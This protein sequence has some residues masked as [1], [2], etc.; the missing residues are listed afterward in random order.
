M[1]FQAQI[2]SQPAP[3]VAGDFASANP[4]S[5]VLTGAGGLVA[6]AL[7]VTVGRFAWITPDGLT[8]DSH[9]DVGRLPDGFVH[10]DMQA[11]I[12]TYLTESGMTIPAGFAVTLHNEGDFW[13]LNTGPAALGIND[14]IFANYK[15]GSIAQAAGANASA[16]GSMGATFTATGTGTS[17]V[18]TA[19]TGVITPGET[20]SG[21]G[22]PVGTT[23]VGQVSGTTGGAG[24][25]TTSVATTAAAA[26][27]TSFGV[28]LTVTAVASGSL[29]VGEP[30]TGT[31]IPAL[32]TIA[33]QVSGATG[34]VGTYRLTL[35][36][37][38]YA[39]S[40][41]VTS[42]TSVAV[43]GFKAKSIAAVGE[44]VKM[45]TWG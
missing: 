38:A 25:Y 5:S 6:G 8:A 37:T 42:V 16:T 32:A 9:G 12:T 27:V 33:S 1:G 24:T 22:V 17:L 4:R 3:A 40:T 30:V 43:T 28:F 26:T 10:R 35:P 20:I 18:V 44:L 41:T 34:G 29:D 13:A 15:D 21:T 23:I 14:A 2:N 11:L 31:G 19:V 36:A 45:S 39:A 7:G